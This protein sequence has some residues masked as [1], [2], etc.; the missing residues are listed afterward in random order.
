MADD[1][2]KGKKD[3]LDI[4]DLLESAGLVKSAGKVGDEKEA[5]SRVDGGP[6]EG[7]GSDSVT[8]E[9]E[10]GQSL[11]AG[12]TQSQ[13]S[14]EEEELIRL[15]EKLGMPYIRMKDYDPD[16]T[17]ITQ[18]PPQVAHLYRVFPI[19]RGT[20][21]ILVVAMAQP[22]NIRTIDDLEQLLSE[23]VKGAIAK[24]EDVNKL[25]DDYF[26]QVDSSIESI[27]ENISQ[28][29]VNFAIREDDIGNLEK[30]VN[31]PPIIRLVN[32][33]LLQAVKD[34]ASDLHLEP[35]QE[36]FRIRY[37]VD[38]A[39]H[40]TKPPPVALQSAIISRIKVMSN[41]DISEN[42]MPQ[43]GRIRLNISNRDVDL[44]VS[45][46]PTV[47]GE[48]IVLRILD[49]QNAM[50]GLEQSGMTPENM[51]IFEKVIKRPN[52]I[53]LVTGPT[54]SGKTTTLYGALQRI[55]NPELKVIT[56]ENPVEYEFRGVVQVNINEEVGL[57]FAACLRS[58]LRQ[59]PDV[60]MVGEIRDSETAKI[61]IEASLTGHLVLST[62]HTN[63]A[64]SAV[65]RLVDM[66]V[67]PFLITSSVEAVVAQR[68]VRKICNRCKQPYTATDEDLY[69]LGVNPED[70]EGVTFFKGA[71]C[72]DCGFSG[73]KGR[74]GIFEMFV[75]SDAV[76]DMI[77][78]RAPSS[79]IFQQ[80]R[81]E[82]MLTLRE[83]GWKKI[84]AGLTTIDEVVRETTE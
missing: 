30:V 79:V 7:T 76:R 22:E 74:L 38:G 50:V 4:D 16:P 33:I 49:Q 71:G 23:P 13:V 59:D 1:K 17:V 32:L 83:D 5:G 18:F 12:L 81:D 47:G 41:M 11:E 73:Y 9:G 60:I 21:D 61:A 29:S 70:V 35:F 20:D 54:G 57:T 27:L 58:I 64:P 84:V 62:L 6:I 48:S 40:E 56:V 8:I 45:T 26:G 78:A 28:E 66:G 65:T 34:R 14:T 67:E 44:R 72:E 36:T 77:L 3:D 82:G 69:D 46:L 39:L 43:D 68:L 31:Q 75:L 2:R 25:I 37:R 63:D 42:R 51:A 15:A 55:Y 52:G 19:T 24:P 10:W 53:L 80:A